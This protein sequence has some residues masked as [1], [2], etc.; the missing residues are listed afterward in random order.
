MY[1]VPQRYSYVI[2]SPITESPCSFVRHLPA[3]MW[4]RYQNKWWCRK[5]LK[6]ANLS[7]YT[8]VIQGDSFPDFPF[9]SAIV[10]LVFLLYPEGFISY[11]WCQS[12]TSHRVPVLLEIKLEKVEESHSKI[13][14]FVLCEN[15]FS[16]LSPASLAKILDF[17]ILFAD[18][19]KF[20]FFSPTLSE[21]E[22]GWMSTSN[23]KSVAL[24][25]KNICSSK[26]FS[27]I[28]QQSVSQELKSDSWNDMRLMPLECF[29]LI[30]KCGRL[31]FLSESVGEILI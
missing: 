3:E 8:I 2:L 4:Y 18:S 26:Y 10:T 31:M 13:L 30:E 20:I 1:K 24:C 29:M 7:E 11:S 16:N 22:C 19:L 5:K 23:S 27:L 14:I 9:T 21:I 15:L 17:H 6:R 28:P 25:T 12:C